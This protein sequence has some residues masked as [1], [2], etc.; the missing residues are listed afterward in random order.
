MR[1]GLTFSLLGFV[2]IFLGGTRL[3]FLWV[4]KQG[5]KASEI[6]SHVMGRIVDILTNIPT[7]K[8]F[9][10]TSREMGKLEPP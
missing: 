7:I 9:S 10:K 5:K 8:L 3:G 4:R 1:K 6:R 2:S